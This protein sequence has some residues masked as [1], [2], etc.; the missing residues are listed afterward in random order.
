[1]RK[2][3][4]HCVFI[5]VLCFCLTIFSQGKKMEELYKK[6]DLLIIEFLDHCYTNGGSNKP[7][8]IKVVGW[9][10]TDTPTYIVLAPWVAENS[11]DDDNT[12]TYTLVKHPNIKIQKAKIE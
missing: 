10:V 6:D 9:V 3:M 11:V 8:P 5:F 7:I 4:A 12:D 1:M 2:F